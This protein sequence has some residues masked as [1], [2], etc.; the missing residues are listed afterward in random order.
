MSNPEMI[1][2]RLPLGIG[3]GER[4]LFFGDGAQVKRLPIDAPQEAGQCGKWREIKGFERD[5]TGFAQK[6]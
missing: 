6:E 5:A 3:A 2:D 4:G 1:T